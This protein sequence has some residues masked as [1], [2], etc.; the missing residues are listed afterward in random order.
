MTQML[1]NS[2]I[3]QFL[4]SNPFALAVSTLLVVAGSVWIA[5]SFA[6]DRGKHEAREGF[7]RAVSSWLNISIYDS[8]HPASHSSSYDLLLD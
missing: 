8:N 3:L 7:S 1:L 2:V 5:L 6:R 4:W